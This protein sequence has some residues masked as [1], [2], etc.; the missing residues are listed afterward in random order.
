MR[1]WLREGFYGGVSVALVAALFLVWLW[2]PEHQVK[3]HTSNLLHALSHKNWPR[4]SAMIGDDYRDQWDNNRASVV[5][6]T[7]EVFRYLNGVTFRTVAPNVRLE[8]RDAYW[9]ANISIDGND[10]EVMAVV[11]ERI[12]TLNSPFELEWH[13]MSW[14]PWDWRLVRVRNEQLTIPAGFE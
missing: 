11:Q 7:R 4:F 10:S 14:K 3:L 1:A 13:R 2:R 6:R 8:D 9:R 5:E 12:N